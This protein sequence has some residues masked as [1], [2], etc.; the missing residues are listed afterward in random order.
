MCGPSA[1]VNVAAS[2]SM[3]FNEQAYSNHLTLLGNGMEN[4]SDRHTWT[5]R[6]LTSAGT[7]VSRFCP[8]TATE[9]KQMSCC[10]A[11]S[12][13]SMAAPLRSTNLSASHT[14]PEGSKWICEASS[15]PRKMLNFDSDMHG[16]PTAK[17][18]LYAA[19]K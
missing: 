10:V 19:S 6:A 1:S 9:K 14:N 11:S 13:V 16:M 18:L 17:M 2:S 8:C 12:S 3:A 15:M 5:R 7:L 4:T